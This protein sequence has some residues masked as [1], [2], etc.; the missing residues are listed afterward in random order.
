MATL[1][2]TNSARGD[3]L[4]VVGPI[5]LFTFYLVTLGSNSG[6]MNFLGWLGVAGLAYSISVS[7]T[8]LTLPTFLRV[9]VCVVGV[10]VI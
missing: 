9:L 7:Y 4:W 1:K 10:L 5:A 8:H 6:L 2:Q 3:W